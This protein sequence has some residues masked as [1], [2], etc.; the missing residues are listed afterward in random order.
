MECGFI[1]KTDRGLQ[2]EFNNIFTSNTTEVIVT[3]NNELIDAVSFRQSELYSVPENLFNKFPNL[4]HLDVELTQMKE[5]LSENFRGANELKYFLARFNE[6]SILRN[7]TFLF[8]RRLKFIVLQYNMIEIIDSGAFEG[9]EKL[10]ALYLDYNKL[11]TISPGLLDSVRSL[12]HFSVA[13]NSLASVP[14]LLFSYNEKLETLNFGHNLLESFDGNQF[15][16]LPNL[17]HVQ[18]DHNKL[19][20]LDLRTCKST[21]INVDKNEI[22]RL[23]LNKWTRFVSATGGNQIK[24]LILHEHYGTGRTYNFSFSEVNE[25]VFFVNKNCCTLESLENFYLLTQ[26]FGDLGNKDLDVNEWNCRFSQTLEYITPNGLVANNVCTKS[27]ASIISTE[28]ETLFSTTRNPE[29]FVTN[30]ESQPS[31]S[32][33]PRESM[34]DTSLSTNIFSGMNIETLNEKLTTTEANSYTGYV[35]EV[36]LTSNENSY[37][38]KCEKGIFKTV[39]TKVIGWKNKVVTKWNDWVG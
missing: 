10:E 23:E 31:S 13:Y 4:K 33:K 8:S 24:T 19:K 37:E 38:K 7:Q 30:G 32:L 1:E 6:I 25:I 20:E 17:E 27:A 29:D 22:E 2:C 34:E 36:S 28:K 3:E 14:E 21:E 39:K 11:K 15:K 12:V 26:S 18:F 9:L 5:I 16:Y 35:E